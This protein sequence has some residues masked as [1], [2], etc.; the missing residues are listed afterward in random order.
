MA[1]AQE[2]HRRKSAQEAYQVFSRKMKQLENL[3]ADF[4]SGAN[5]YDLMA[6][7]LRVVVIDNPKSKSR[8]L[9]STLGV[10]TK[11]RI[12]STVEPF[13][14]GNLLPNMGLVSQRVSATGARYEAL[15]QNSPSGSRLLKVDDWLTEI[16]FKA[17]KFVLNR[18]DVIQ[19]IAD[20]DGGA[21]FDR[22]YEERHY[23]LSK[24]NVLGWHVKYPDGR[25]EQFGDPFPA[26]IR[27]VAH[28]VLK[29]NSLL[30]AEG[31]LSEIASD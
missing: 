14:E 31:W 30:K 21:H 18:K 5:N 8:S 16:V 25:S 28:E 3:A 20:N 1:K 24:E 2:E 26:A 22:F 4:D 7:I 23:Q 29:M 17:G 6:I 27:Q 15:L 12:L 9:L 19:L 13:N 11:T 10:G